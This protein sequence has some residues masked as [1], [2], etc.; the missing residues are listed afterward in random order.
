MVHNKK[1]ETH[2]SFTCFGGNHSFNVLKLCFLHYNLD[3]R[4]DFQQLV[5][6]ICADFNIPIEYE[7]FS[8][9]GGKR[10]SKQSNKR[11]KPISPEELKNIQADLNT[12]IEPL[13][14]FM[15]Y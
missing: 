6:K 12:S 13:K 4:N 8:L 10:I 1:I 9:T 11:R 14:I 3:T 5:E 2:T 15:L 7:E